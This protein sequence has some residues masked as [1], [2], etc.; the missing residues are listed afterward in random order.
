MSKPRRTISKTGLHVQCTLTHCMSIHYISHMHRVSYGL[1]K[2]YHCRQIRLLND[3]NG[4]HWA[5]IEPCT[6]AHWCKLTSTW[7]E[8]IEEVGIN[9]CAIQSSVLEVNNIRCI[10]YQCCC[11]CISCASHTATLQLSTIG[12]KPSCSTADSAGDP[13]NPIWTRYLL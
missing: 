1:F 6:R 3:N 5:S 12:S 8:Q 10:H 9:I 13:P 4:S 2:W 11:R 7:D